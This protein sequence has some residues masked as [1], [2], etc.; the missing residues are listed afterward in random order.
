MDCTQLGGKLGPSCIASGAP[1]LCFSPQT[2]KQ[3]V[4]DSCNEAVQPRM[5]GYHHHRLLGQP[6]SAHCVPCCHET[7][8]QANPLTMRKRP[9][10]SSAQ[11]CTATWIC[12][13]GG[14]C[15]GGSSLRS[16]LRGWEGGRVRLR[17]R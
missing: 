3:H 10:M 16:S 1:G 11:A 15:G 6:H 13:W 5:R 2:H 17:I 12:V 14:K 7:S 9:A 4:K 8:L